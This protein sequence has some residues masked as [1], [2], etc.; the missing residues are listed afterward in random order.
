ME[1]TPPP[2]GSVLKPRRS[3]SSYFFLMKDGSPEPWRK[4]KEYQLSPP[5]HMAVLGFFSS[6]D[7]V[8]S[9]ISITCC[10]SSSALDL[11]SQPLT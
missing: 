11:S 9:F 3:L 7:F 10:R 1:V 8:N 6:M 2:V 4:S 5:G